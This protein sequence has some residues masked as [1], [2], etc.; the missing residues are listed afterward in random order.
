MLLISVWAFI[1]FCALHC[2]RHKP[3]MAIGERQ[4]LFHVYSWWICRR[5]TPLSFHKVSQLGSVFSIIRIGHVDWHRIYNWAFYVVCLLTVQVLQQGGESGKCAINIVNPRVAHVALGFLF[6][7]QFM[8]AG[9]SVGTLNPFGAGVD[10]EVGMIWNTQKWQNFTICLS[11]VSYCNAML[12]ARDSIKWQTWSAAS[13]LTH[14]F[15]IFYIF[16]FFIENCISRT[17]LLI[18]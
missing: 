3:I 7:M 5:I 18:H 12:C 13:C 4:R 15:F 17:A 6:R 10:K 1:I 14:S 9:G 16:L 11:T 2:V 8:H